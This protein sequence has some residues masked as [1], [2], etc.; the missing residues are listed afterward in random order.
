MIFAHSPYRGLCPNRPGNLLC[1]SDW[2]RLRGIS[3]T[4]CMILPIRDLA[5]FP[6]A[7]EQLKAVERSSA[8]LPLSVPV[9]LDD[10]RRRP[11][12]VPWYGSAGRADSPCSGRT[13]SI[14]DSEPDLWKWDFDRT[15]EYCPRVPRPVPQS[16]VPIRPRPLLR[17][18][19]L[20]HSLS[21]PRR[22]IR[23]SPLTKSFFLPHSGGSRTPSPPHSGGSRTPSPPQ[24]CSR[25]L[26]T[27]DRSPLT[28][29]PPLRGAN[30]QWTHHRSDTHPSLRCARSI[31]ACNILAQCSAAA[32]KEQ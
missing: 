4:E 5:A 15:G 12:Q 17:E 24:S 14:Y 31:R 7:C 16:A 20:P 28:F 8:Q 6:R 19:I 22:S 23:G 13:D 27:S 30:H 1:R 3:E 9:L 10:C 18:R 2:L 29:L 26:S 32:N 11:D 21:D 25:P